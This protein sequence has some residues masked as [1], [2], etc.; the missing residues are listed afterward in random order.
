MDDHTLEISNKDGDIV[1]FE[2][3]TSH[4]IS[5]CG[6][7][8]V[9]SFEVNSSFPY[10]NKKAK[11]FYD[12]LTIYLCLYSLIDDRNVLI[13]MDVKGGEVNYDGRVLLRHIEDFSLYKL[14]QSSGFNIQDAGY[15]LK[16]HRPLVAMTLDV[17]KYLG[18]KRKHSRAYKEALR[19]FHRGFYP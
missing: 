12:V 13:M 10:D 8:T 3:S 16:T 18:G 17:K 7:T 5:C 1:Q 9:H 6:A 14:G 19:L 15:N 2:V 11:Y 4:Y